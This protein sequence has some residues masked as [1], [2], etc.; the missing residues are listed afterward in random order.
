[1]YNTVPDRK[2]ST[3]AVN[4]KKTANSFMGLFF[5]FWIF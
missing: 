5:G 2:Q 3:N 1:M 4:A